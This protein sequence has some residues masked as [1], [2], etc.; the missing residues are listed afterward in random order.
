MSMRRAIT[1]ACAL[2]AWSAHA[3]AALGAETQAVSATASEI[4]PLERIGRGIF[5]GPLRYRHE[6]RDDFDFRSDRDDRDDRD[7]FKLG[8]GIDARPVDAL[9]GRVQARVTRSW[10]RDV[11]NTSARIDP[12]GQDH[13]DIFEAFGEIGPF[14]GTPLSLRLGRQVL[15]FG[16]ERLIGPLEFVQNARSFDAARAIFGEGSDLEASAFWGRLVQFEGTDDHNL[17][18]PVETSDLFGLYATW[19]PLPDLLVDA[20]YLAKYDDNHVVAS[21]TGN[22]G[23]H[24]LRHSPGAR[25]VFKAPAGFAFYADG[26]VQFGESGNDEIFAWGAAAKVIWTAPEEIRPLWQVEAEYIYGSGDTNPADGTIGTLDNFYPTNHKFYGEMDLA[27]WQ[28]I[29]DL[30]LTTRIEV[31]RRKLRDPPGGD[32]KGP[33]PWIHERAVPA[34]VPATLVV[35]LEMGFHALWLA[36]TSDAWYNAPLRVVRRD[37]TGAANRELGQE[38]DIVLRAGPVNLGYGHFFAGAYVRDTTPAGGRVTGAD[39]FWVEVALSF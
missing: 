21:E 34:L 14:A 24:A 19:K 23:H 28:N 18:R 32:G 25:G 35:T 26:V 20:F 12:F 16:E 22:P 15:A 11:V 39:F 2:F 30:E 5:L 4:G 7:L 10:G 3:E 37:P 29:H 33:R 6:Y 36:S 27:S 13:L 31:F 38:V 9:R 8:F 1:L 17:N